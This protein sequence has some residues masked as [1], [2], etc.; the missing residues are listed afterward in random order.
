M[1]SL[2]EKKHKGGGHFF[3]DSK[4]LRNNGKEN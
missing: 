2:S 4:E 1:A 3:Q